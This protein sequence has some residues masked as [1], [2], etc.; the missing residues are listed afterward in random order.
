MRNAVVRECI[1]SRSVRRRM[2]SSRMHSRAGPHESCPGSLISN[3]WFAMKLRENHNASDD[4]AVIKLIKSTKK[5]RTIMRR[6]KLWP[7]HMLDFH[8]GVADQAT[9]AW[10]HSL[11]EQWK[12]YKFVCP[13]FLS[14]IVLIFKVFI[15]SSSFFYT[16]FYMIRIMRYQMMV[17]LHN[18]RLCHLHSMNPKFDDSK[19]RQ[20]SAL[21]S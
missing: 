13:T 7:K 21:E 16:I 14:V 9:I 6:A 4:G 10:G 2:H 12:V 8:M 5:T 15:T 1:L 3:H 18:G 11:L 20:W 17:W 19:C